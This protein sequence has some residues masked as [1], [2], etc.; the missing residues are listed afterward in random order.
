MDPFALAIKLTTIAKN[1]TMV[2]TCCTILK[3]FVA[4]PAL[5]FGLFPRRY[6]SAKAT[7]ILCFSASV[8]LGS[9]FRSFP[10]RSLFRVSSFMART[11][12][13]SEPTNTF[14]MRETKE[15]FLI[16]S[17]L[18]LLSVLKPR[19]WMSKVNLLLNCKSRSSF[20]QKTWFTWIGFL[21][22]TTNVG[23]GS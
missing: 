17:A 6:P 2:N 13:L 7:F 11:S 23:T 1:I 16:D 15:G 10:K 18:T 4:F 21:L 5:M 14:L 22:D 19:T 20:L 9:W 8:M 12:P 3:Y